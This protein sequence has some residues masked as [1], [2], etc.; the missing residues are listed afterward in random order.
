MIELYNGRW[1]A[2]EGEPVLVTDLEKHEDRR[3]VVHGW[4][5]GI[6]RA[7]AV[8]FLDIGDRTGSVQAV[9]RHGRVADL[10]ALTVGSAVR[11]VGV[12]R[13]RASE[14]FGSMEVELEDL[15]VIG[16][17]EGPLP[18]TAGADPESRL[19]HRYLDLRRREAA[20]VFEVQ[21][22]LEAAMREF[23][24]A[25]S[26]LEVHTPKITA[27]GSESG[28]A[29]FELSYF[30]E[31]ACLVQSPQFYMQ[32]AM[33]AGLDR[34][35]E[36]GPVFRA[37]PATT[38]RHAA[39]FTCVDVERAWIESHHD[40]MHLQEELLCHALLA[41]RA[42]HGTDIERCFGVPVEVPAVPILRVPAS[43]AQELTEECGDPS[44]T[45]LPHRAEQLLSKYALEQS[46]QSFIFVVEYPASERPFY[47]MRL[48]GEDARAP[49]DETRSFDLLWRG[50]EISSGCQREHRYDRLRAQIAAAGLEPGTLTQYLH[51]YYLDMFRFGCPSHG[52]F[53]L[54]LNRVLMSLLALP[55]IRETSFAFRGPGR[56]VP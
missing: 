16:R 26:F 32:F 6:R 10:D 43:F 37:E 46:G 22:T 25:H 28:A 27:G 51:T 1:S 20:V 5:S 33:A 56:F 23:L 48:D 24:L 29:V 36:V 15:E 47:T 40:L 34:V 52:G 44:G 30:G 45:H 7:R 2:G 50:L 3:V 54:G 17:A 13:R 53:G 4:L 31:T 8:R 9:H 38:N 19:D 18:L 35:F 39:E 11:V 42:A 12:A 21:T 14:R 41:V 49:R 55:S